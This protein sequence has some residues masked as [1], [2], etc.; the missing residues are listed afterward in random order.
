MEEKCVT[1]D[2]RRK[3]SLRLPHHEHPKVRQLEDTS[4]YHDADTSNYYG[5]DDTSNYYGDDDYSETQCNEVLAFFLSFVSWVL[6]N[7]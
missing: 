1:P 4:Y 6:H 7:V 2:T 5:D 3:L